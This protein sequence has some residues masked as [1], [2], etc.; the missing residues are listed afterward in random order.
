MQ[1][2]VE[3]KLPLG[4]AGIDEKHTAV[5]P[6]RLLHPGER[7]GVDVRAVGARREAGVAVG[8][9][10]VKRERRAGHGVAIGEHLTEAGVE[11]NQSVRPTAHLK[12][13]LTERFGH[14]D[15]EAG[16]AEVGLQ[17]LLRP[18]LVD[19]VRWCCMRRRCEH[20][21][22]SGDRGCHERRR[23]PVPHG[24]PPVV[25]MTTSSA[26]AH[27]R[28]SVPARNHR[29]PAYSPGFA[30]PSAEGSPPKQHLL[31]PRVLPRPCAVPARP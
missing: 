25:P 30:P 28:A 22:Q 7:L 20:R 31:D 21:R 12:T 5:R 27:A 8:E 24:R 17:P 23:R 4:D 2:G 3:Q 15:V 1:V 29:A 16:A 26:N 19:V 6:D 14:G 10:A 11:P 18:P 13:V 9:P